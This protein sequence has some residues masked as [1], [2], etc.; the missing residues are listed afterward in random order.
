MSHHAQYNS[1]SSLSSTHRHRRRKHDHDGNHHKKSRRTNSSSHA[2]PSDYAQLRS[3]FQFV[4]PEDDGDGSTCQKYGSTWQQRM[5]LHYH[6]HLY[7]EYVLAD[8]SRVSKGGPIGLRWRTEGEVK[9]GRGFRSCGN[10][11]CVQQS[12]KTLSTEEEYTRRARAALGVGVAENGGKIPTGV[13]LPNEEASEA[14]ES[15]L[16]SCEEEERRS[17]KKRANRERRRKNQRENKSRGDDD[18]SQGKESRRQESKE[19]EQ[20]SRVPHGIGLH[21][22]EVDFAYVEHNQ[23]KRELVKVRLCL[24]CA[25]LIFSGKNAATKARQ[26]REKAAR[27]ASATCLGGE[28]ET[29]SGDHNRNNRHDSIHENDGSIGEENNG[30]KVDN[31]DRKKSHKRRHRK[32]SSRMSRSNSL[33]SSSASD[34]YCSSDDCA[35]SLPSKDREKE[36]KSAKNRLKK[37]QREAGFA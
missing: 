37:R 32:D 13:V 28:A 19:Q 18:S 17:R 35:L 9:S 7:K 22:Y 30:K 3:H 20:L 36:L 5:V 10:L 24:R 8:L 27:E 31:V 11:A 26:A 14:I 2:A 4:L 25:P 12:Q 1:D 21:D 15:Y 16:R 33:S 29:T 23:Q 6:S 34:S